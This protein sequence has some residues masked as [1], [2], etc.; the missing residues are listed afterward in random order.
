[1]AACPWDS[2]PILR[3]QGAVSAS[4][5]LVANARLKMG[6]HALQVPCITQIQK[7]DKEKAA[8]ELPSPA[9]FALLLKDD[10]MI[11]GLMQCALHFRTMISTT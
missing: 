6:V 8:S 7:L 11:I 3:S 1:M 9:A 10:S 4:S 5:S 2:I